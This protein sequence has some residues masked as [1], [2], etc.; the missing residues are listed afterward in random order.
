M[1][2]S[3]P[4]LN[5]VS[6]RRHQQAESPL[7]ANSIVIVDAAVN[8]HQSLFKHL[9]GSMEVHILNEQEDGITQIKSLLQQ[10]QSLSKLHLVCTGAPG[11]IELGTTLLSEINLWA[12]A[13]AIRQW[14]NYLTYDAEI[15]IHGC[16]LATNRMGQAFVSWLGLLT[17]SCVKVA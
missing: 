9:L 11:Q 2:Y 15:L 10:Y 1:P 16:D 13:D 12:Y 6:S 4:T 14:R 7:K 8:Q 3:V 5:P 17:R